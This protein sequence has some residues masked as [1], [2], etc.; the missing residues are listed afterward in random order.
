MVQLNKF[1]FH[2]TTKVDNENISINLPSNKDIRRSFRRRSYGQ[3]ASYVDTDATV[4]DGECRIYSLPYDFEFFFD[5][6]N[7]FQGGVFHKVRQLKMNDKIYFEHELFQIIS[8]DFPFLEYLYIFNTRRMKHKKH[9]STLITF[10]NLIHLD[11]KCAHTDYALL[12]L[13]KRNAHLPR[14]AN[15]CI[16]NKSLIK[17]TNNF[18]YDAMRFNF[19]KLKTLQGRKS[20]VRSKN[21]HKYFPFL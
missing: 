14:L 11:L 8:Q 1:T 3:V 21:F 10:P 9:S 5:L 16:R 6:D 4:F 20:F 12:F 7:S 17:I 13:L 2:I 18:T 15:L 19:D